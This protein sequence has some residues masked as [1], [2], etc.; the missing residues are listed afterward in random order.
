MAQP[1]VRTAAPNSST[2]SGINAKRRVRIPFRAVIMPSSPSTA[3]ASHQPVCGPMG[4]PPCC[5]GGR[6]RGVVVRVNTVEATA[7]P[8]V[9]DAGL[10]APVV[11]GGKLVAVKVTAFGNPPA[12]GVI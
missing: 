4:A 2:A 5:G 7:L 9:K 8:G 10:N 1:V 11:L 6:V 12:A 3:A